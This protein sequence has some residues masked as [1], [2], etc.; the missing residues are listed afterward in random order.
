MATPSQH[1]D[2]RLRVLVANNP[3]ADELLALLG[4]AGGATGGQSLSYYILRN[5]VADDPIAGIFGTIGAAMAWVRDNV[6]DNLPVQFLLSPCEFGDAHPFTDEGW[7]PNSLR[8]V[9]IR[10]GVG[11]YTY[12]VSIGNVT[13]PGSPGFFPFLY[14]VNCEVRQGAGT[15]FTLGQTRAL[16][17]DGVV[18]YGTAGSFIDFDDGGLVLAG[19]D[20][21]VN[22]MRCVSS[23]GGIGY[24][25]ELHDAE[26]R[27][28]GTDVLLDD[29][30]LGAFFADARIYAT[31]TA[32]G[33]DV[34]LFRSAGVGSVAFQ[35]CNLFVQQQTTAVA[36]VLLQGAAGSE[37]TYRGLTISPY[38]SG[39]ATCRLQPANWTTDTTPGPVGLSSYV[40]TGVQMTLPEAATWLRQTSNQNVGASGETWDGVSYAVL[41]SSAIGAGGTFLL[42]DAVTQNYPAGW[43]LEWKNNDGVNSVDITPAGGQT[44]DG[45]A[46]LATGAARSSATLTWDGTSDWMVS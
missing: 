40:S 39:S 28:Q 20:T 9:V 6:P 4:A 19:A 2:T 35:G 17:I 14:F 22:S 7:I 23:A 11:S 29:C 10:G 30:E 1:L 15:T 38:V 18:W 32:V 33:A 34:V 43:F 41:D 3:D 37:A 45:A 25:A 16:W 5:A 26:V 31:M 36:N 46:L 44:I 13:L 42:P 21:I 24:Y 27:L 8:E 12:R